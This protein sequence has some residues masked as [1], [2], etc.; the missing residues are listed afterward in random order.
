ARP[1]APRGST[2]GGSDRRE[3]AR[4]GAGARPTDGRGIVSGEIETLGDWSRTDMCGALRRADVGREVTLCGWVQARRDHGGVLFIDLRDR[5]GLVQLVCNPTDS[6][7]S[8]ARAGTVRHE[9]VIAVRGS[10][11]ERPAAPVNPDLPRGHIQVP[12]AD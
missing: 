5:S 7:T 10:A 6:P 1:R 12:A 8:H 4:S 3:R 11:R 9:Y 2:A